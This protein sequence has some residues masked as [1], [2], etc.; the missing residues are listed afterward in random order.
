M[1]TSTQILTLLE[2]ADFVRKLAVNGFAIASQIIGEACQ[3][4]W[5]R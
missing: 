3:H 1:L 5:T 4:Q 2:D